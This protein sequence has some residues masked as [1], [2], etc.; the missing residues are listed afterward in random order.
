MTTVIPFLP[1]NL[2][3]PSF[4]VTLDQDQYKIIVTWNV[5]AQRYYINVY[6]LD[7]SWVV[8]VPLIQTPPSRAINS[9]SYDILRRVMTVG[10][11]G[12]I[13]YPIPLGSNLT[14]PGTIVDYTLENFDPPILNQTWR[15]LH[16]NDNT[17]SFPLAD[18]PGQINIVGTVA[19]LMN[20]VGGVFINST[21]AY[22]NGAFE[23]TP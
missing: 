10:L 23:V 12:P 1:S 2:T 16:I 3:A 8:T 14:P 15:S 11:V 19:R 17:F 4:V 21:L 13:Y 22:R 18:D 5:S 7:G 20:M 9:I 6:G